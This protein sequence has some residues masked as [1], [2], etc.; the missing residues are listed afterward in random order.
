MRTWLPTNV[1]AVERAVRIVVG[2]GLLS[3]T[4]FGPRTAWG[5]LGL[6]PLATGLVGSCPLYTV[7]GFSTC[8]PKA[9]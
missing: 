1:H 9:P 3:L 6:I 7:F 2:V 8:R 4:V 5:L